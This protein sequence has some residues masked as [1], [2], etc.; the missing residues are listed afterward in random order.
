MSEATIGDQAPD[1]SLPVT[2]G[3]TASLSGLRGKAVVVYFYPKDD[4]SACTTEAIGFTS[5]SAEFAAAG[6]V[7]I[8]ISPDDM[9]SHE[10]FQKKHQLGVLLASDQD[11]TVAE[12]F[13]V[14]K[15]KSMYGRTY[16]GIERSTFLIDQQGVIREAWRKVKVAGHAEAVLEAVRAL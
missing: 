3:D 8:G 12:A 15:E 6:A 9:K 16:M 4:T 7:V 1:F 11:H 10:K 5:L 14:W 13:G 2:G